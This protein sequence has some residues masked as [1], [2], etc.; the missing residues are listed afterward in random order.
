MKKETATTSA[1]IFAWRPLAASCPFSLVSAVVIDLPI[2]I[3]DDATG[4]GKEVD[5]RSAAR[6]S[7]DM[8]SRALAEYARCSRAERLNLALRRNIPDAAG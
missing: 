2:K 4:N 8:E 5:R 7:T 1:T 6:G 3:P